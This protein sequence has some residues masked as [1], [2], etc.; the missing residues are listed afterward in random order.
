MPRFYRPLTLEDRKAVHR[1]G[2]IILMIYSSIVLALTAGVVAHIA[3][4]KP[5]IA[6]TQ[7]KRLRRSMP[8]IIPSRIGFI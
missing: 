4:K 3:F 2:R 7:F 1:T 8:S 5:T 6:N